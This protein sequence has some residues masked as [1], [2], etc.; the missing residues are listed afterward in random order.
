MNA[1]RPCIRKG[2]GDERICKV[3]DS[4]NM[5]EAECTFKIGPGGIEN[6]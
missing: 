5:P 6:A 4:P 1:R 2:R 3:Y